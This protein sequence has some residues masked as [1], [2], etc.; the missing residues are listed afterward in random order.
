M[1]VVCDR[2]RLLAADAARAFFAEV[3]AEARRHRLLSAEHFTVDGTLL[4]AW[5][6]L[7]SYRPRDWQEPPPGGGRTRT[8]TSA[9]YDTRDFVTALRGRGVTPHVAP[10]VRRRL[11][12]V[13][14][15][16]TRHT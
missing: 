15:L 11:S 14:G 10:N 6:S 13:H 8:W 3:V 9:G 2:E 1:V 5:A 16:T 12:A 4:E 7:K